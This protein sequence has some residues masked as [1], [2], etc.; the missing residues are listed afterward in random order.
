MLVTALNPHIGY[1]KA[2]ACAKKAHK[3]GTTL[4]HAALALG[5]V[6]EAEFEAWVKPEQMVG[7]KEKKYTSTEVRE[8]EEAAA[9]MEKVVQIERDRLDLIGKFAEF[10]SKT[11]TD[12]DGKITLEEFKRALANDDMKDCIKKLRIPL[13]WTAEEVFDILDEQR[14]GY[15]TAGDLVLGF[16]KFHG[17][18]ERALRKSLAKRSTE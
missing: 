17:E 2:A 1:D 14:H 5:H 6:T 18:N 10:F 12:G 16:S 11:D 7:P 13:G 3:E 4:K 15:F 8:R 9:A